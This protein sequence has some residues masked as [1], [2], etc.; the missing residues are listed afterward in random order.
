MDRQ[1]AD[2]PDRGHY[3]SI[4]NSRCRL[5]LKPCNWKFIERKKTVI[6]TSMELGWTNRCHYPISELHL[7]R[8]IFDCPALCRQFRSMKH[9][10][11]QLARMIAIV[12]FDGRLLWCYTNQIM[13]Q[14]TENVANGEYAQ[15]I[16]AVEKIEFLK[17]RW[18]HF[19]NLQW[20]CTKKR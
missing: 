4:R 9:W 17:Y 12:Q 19:R 11:I 1:V 15:H 20:E 14:L 6:I 10:A 18:T 3:N 7:P 8:F 5:H 13:T 2:S 16:G